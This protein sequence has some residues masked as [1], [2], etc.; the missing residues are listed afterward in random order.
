MRAL[1]R[2]E[3][4]S[5]KIVACYS[6]SHWPFVRDHFLPSVPSGSELVLLKLPQDTLAGH[7]RDAN[8]IRMANRKLEFLVRLCRAEK[9]TFF[10]SDVDARFYAPL[11]PM[12]DDCDIA[13]QD[14]GEGG[15]CSGSLYVRP[16]IDTELLF[17][18][19]RSFLSQFGGHDQ[20]AFGLA[21]GCSSTTAVAKKLPHT[22]WSH[23]AT[24]N[25]IWEPG[26][27]L[28]DPPDGIV[29]HQANWCL[30][31]E[32]KMALLAEVHRRVSARA[33]V[34]AVVS[35]AGE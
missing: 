23:G 9:D 6:E 15:L 27:P 29:V 22:F 12:P 17:S 20:P 5:V 31:V 10:F 34:K 14:D 32:N 16:S 28:P 2:H 33:V 1:Q 25:R 11:P 24:E 8:R 13:A 4:D 3:E 30:G 26:D 7:Y 19:A 35:H 18:R 21:L